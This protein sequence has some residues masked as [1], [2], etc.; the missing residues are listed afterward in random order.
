MNI[1][2]EISKRRFPLALFCLATFIPLLGI[3]N[4]ASAAKVTRPGLWATQSVWLA[5]ACGIAFVI[6][7]FPTRLLHRFAYPIYMAVNVLLVLVLVAGLRIKG[8]QRWLDLG[9]FHLQPSELAKVAIILV[10]ARYFAAY[11]V[12]QGY[13]LR[14][15]FRPFNLSRVFLG[16]G[17]FI[18]G[19]IQQMNGTPIKG[20]ELPWW[21]WGLCLLGLLFLT[22]WCALRLR[23][24]GLHHRQLIAPIDIVL[25]P[26][27]L[28]VVEPDLG[29]SLVVLAIA[30]T[31]ILF[32]GIRWQSLIIAG[33]LGALTVVFGWNVLLKD[34]QKQRVE[35]FLNPEADMHGAGYHSI[36]SMIAIGSGQ[37]TGKGFMEGTQTQ[38]S[39]LPENHT[40]F[41]FSVWAEEWG[42]MGAAL[43]IVAFGL[44]LL[45]MIQVGQN[46]KDKFS[47]LLCIGA[48]AMIFWH[49]I[50]NISMVTG[51]LPVVGMTLP[52]VSYGG[53]SLITQV[54]ALGL[55]FNASLG[56]RVPNAAPVRVAQR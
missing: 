35:T 43:L 11:H 42:F 21:G 19:V 48:A 34:Y 28:I 32:C 8:A 30:G 49:V 54:A 29:T 20:Q 10:T 27:A 24:E 53:S 31:M 3:L 40:D 12:P 2:N 25:I 36:Q 41:V 23:S 37:K 15:L 7:F 39:F 55:V 18:T 52:L 22:A 46:S 9:F 56:R 33:I 26:F 6:V 50:I 38:L 4:L 17:V 51:L 16:W 13:T 5:I 47:A 14:M 45:L 1:S 44:L